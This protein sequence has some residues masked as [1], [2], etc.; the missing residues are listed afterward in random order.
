MCSNSLDGLHLATTE[1]YDMLIIDHHLP[2]LSGVK[3][4]QKLRAEKV[5]TPILLMSASD[6]RSLGLDED[7][8]ALIVF[9]PK[10]VTP[11][12]LRFCVQTGL[13]AAQEL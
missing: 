1:R 4:I 10:P 8:T 9:E 13:E 5:T 6:F 12:R 7:E 3:I 11:E 2:E